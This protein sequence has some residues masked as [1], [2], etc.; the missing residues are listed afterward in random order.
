M[1]KVCFWVFHRRVCVGRGPIPGQTAMEPNVRKHSVVLG[2]VQDSPAGYQEIGRLHANL[3]SVSG[4]HV[5]VLLDGEFFAANMSGL[6]GAVLALCAERNQVHIHVVDYRVQ[7]VLRRNG[8]LSRFGKPPLP[9]RYNSAIEYQVFDIGDR[10]AFSDYVDYG[11]LDRGEL[12]TMSRKVKSRILRSVYEIYE[13]ALDHSESPSLFACGQ[14]FWRK[15]QLNVTFV[16]VGIGFR[17]RLRRSKGFDLGSIGSIQWALQEGNTT[18]TGTRPG[19]LGLKDLLEFINLNGG[20]L[21][22]ASESGYWA[23]NPKHGETA[24]TMEVALPGSAVSLEFNTKD[25][26]MYFV[27]GEDVTESGIFA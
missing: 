25:D 15:G 10:Q 17:E 19:G 8:F 23:W 14:Y 13:N 7:G 12:P 5:E 16:D 24:T 27:D 9:D 4:E 3:S 20:S 26:G 1:P 18:R 22:I 11:V 2:S 6:L 21:K